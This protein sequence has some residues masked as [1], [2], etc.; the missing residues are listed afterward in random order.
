MLTDEDARSC[1]KVDDQTD[2]KS[3]LSLSLGCDDPCPCGVIG[4]REQLHLRDLEAPNASHCWRALH[5][6][7]P[8]PSGKERFQFLVFCIVTTSTKNLAFSLGFILHCSF[9]FIIAH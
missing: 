7:F 9:A 1:E 8:V 6:S 3:K 4:D 2:F 5:V